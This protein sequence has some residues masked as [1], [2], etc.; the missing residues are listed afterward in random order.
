MCEA[1]RH[2]V[3]AHKIVSWVRRKLGPEVLVLRYRADGSLG[4]A[5]PCVMC[6]RELNRFDLRV[7][8]PDASGEWFS[9]RMSDTD[10]PPA[11][12]TSGQRRMLNQGFRRATSSH[13]ARPARAETDSHSSSSAISSSNS[14]VDSHCV[15]AQRHHSEQQ[16]PLAAL[17]SHSHL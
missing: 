15:P 2:G 11:F 10:A 5:A 4:C 13:T 14:T 9:G 3:P 17:W 7:H 6:A 8:C 1:R 12:L 16:L